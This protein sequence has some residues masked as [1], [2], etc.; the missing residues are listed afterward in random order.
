MAESDAAAATSIACDTRSRR[1]WIPTAHPHVTWS[2]SEEGGS[3]S[4]GGNGGEKGDDGVKIEHDPQ[5]DP[6]PQQAACAG[7]EQTHADE[8]SG[9]RA[10]PRPQ[11]AQERDAAP[12]LPYQHDLAGEDVEGRDH[13]DQGKHEDQHH[14]L[15][16]QRRDQRAVP[17][18]PRRR[19]EAARLSRILGELWLKATGEGSRIVRLAQEQLKIVEASG[20]ETEEGR[21]RTD[22][23]IGFIALSEAPEDD[24]HAHIPAP[25]G[26]AD[27]S[28][29]AIR[30]YQIEGLAQKR[31]TGPAVGIE[32]GGDA[33]AQR[34]FAPR[35]IHRP[36][37]CESRR[38]PG[39][40]LVECIGGQPADEGAADRPARWQD[41]HAL[42]GDL[43]KRGLH[44]WPVH[45]RG[46]AGLG[47]LETLERSGWGLTG[48]QNPQ[49]DVECIGLRH[50]H[51]RGWRWLNSRQGDVG[52]TA[53][54]RLEQTVALTVEEGA[55][56][57][58][59]SHTDGDASQREQ[60][61]QR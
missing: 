27:D 57:N 44:L 32:I 10:L 53:L 60:L 23:H 52:A 29:G 13:D 14:P 61:R 51:R 31:Q 58:Q 39:Q 8:H 6:Q 54:D 16:P 15:D 2:W 49:R 48:L 1:V 5:P 34:H 26:P 33:V 25:G 55:G 24:I 43:E 30:G 35:Q 50:A 37:E 38:M 4:H 22:V 7:E 20:L 46:N 19:P 28:G 59:R 41:H 3:S 9:D 21:R 17:V 36:G 40:T 45:N 56:D 18:L 47:G 11:R 42:S 12:L